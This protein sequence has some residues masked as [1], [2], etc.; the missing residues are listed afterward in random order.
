ME[1]IPLVPLLSFSFFCF[2][3]LIVSF[4]AS[5]FKDDGYSE[6]D[7]QS[8]HFWKQLTIEEKTEALNSVKE[9]LNAYSLSNY[10]SEKNKS[11]LRNCLLPS[12]KDLNI[13]D[14]ELINYFNTATHLNPNISF[15]NIYVFKHA[16]RIVGAP[17]YAVDIEQR[18]GFY[19]TDCYKEDLS[20]V[21][22]KKCIKN[23]SS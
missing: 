15:K 8:Y 21:F 3:M 2:S 12:I 4:I 9:W 18:S 19:L 7:Q 13:K 23:L 16:L 1:N 22:S 20:L 14:S 6:D 5:N 10:V 17:I 11:P